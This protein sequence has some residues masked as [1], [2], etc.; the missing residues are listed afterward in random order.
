MTAGESA[1]T[2]SAARSRSWL[3]MGL[4]GAAGVG[5]VF[6]LILFAYELA[7]ARVPQ[8]RAA[9]EHLVRVQTGLDVRF[10]ELGLRWGWY[11]PEAVFR[12]VELDEPGSAQALLRAP[13]L[14]VGFDAWRT[15]RSGHPEAGRIEL[16]APEIDFSGGSGGRR[17]VGV[18]AAVQ[19]AVHG[20]S[21]RSAHGAARGVPHGAAPGADGPSAS[22]D[23]SAL[24]RVAVLQRWRGGRIDIEGG[25]L[26]LP[27]VGGGANLFNSVQIRRASLRRS[28]DEWSVAG[29][30]FLPDRVGR[31]ARITL[32]V[33]G[34]L[35]KPAELS[36]TLR[37]EARRLLFPGC[38]D[39][40]AALPDLARYLPRGGNGDVSVDLNFERGQLVKAHGN[41]RA[42]GVVFDGPAG[43]VAD[44]A[45]GG[46]FAALGFAAGSAVVGGPTA[47]GVARGGSM[48]GG[49]GTGA[50]GGSGGFAAGSAAVGGSGAGTGHA[51]DGVARVGPHGGGA[52]GSVGSGGFAPGSSAAGGP[53]TGGGHA[54][55]GVARVGSIGGGGV[56]AGGGPMLGGLAASGDGL[57]VPRANLLV[58]D[59]FRGDWQVTRLGSGWRVRVD[60]L[61]LVRG[62][63]LGSLTLD[64]SDSAVQ[65]A[66]GRWI[67]GTLE[68][69]P[70]ESVLAVARWLAPHF[71][72]AGIQLDGTARTVAFD[73]ASGRQEGQRLQTSARLDDVALVPRSKDFTLSGLGVRVSGTESQL[74]IDVQSRIARLELGQSQ[75]QPLADVHVS[76][77]LHVSSGRDGW[78]IATDEFLLEHQRASL[79]LS[80]SLQDDPI[81]PRIAATGKLIGA[82]IPLVMRLVGENTAQAFGAAASRLTAGRIEN[83]DFALHGP[84][85]KLPFDA[86]GDGFTGSLTLRN[87]V[88]SGGDLWPDADEIAAH[89]EWRGA[90]IQATIEAGHAGPFQLAAA[91]AQ[92][93]ADGGSATRLTGHV[94]GRLED[95]I[96]WVHDHPGL[97]EYVPDMRYVDASGD[98]SFDFN[99]SVPASLAADVHEP[100]VLARVS[101][102]IDGATVQAISGLPALEGVTGSFV[103][104]AGHLKRS[105]LT[106]SWLGGPVT[107]RVGERREKG[108]PV[109]A[110]QA[111]GTLT[112]QRLATLANAT[113]TVEGSTDWTGELAYLQADNAQAPRWRMRADSNLLGV[114]SSLPEPFAKRSAAVVPVHLEVT[115]AS[116][117]AVLRASLGDRVRSLFAL[118][119]RPDVGWA[120]DRGA[121]R[122]GAGAPVLPSEPVVLVRGRVSELDLPAYAVAWTRLRRDSLPTIRAQMVADEMLVGGRRYNDVSLQ[123]ERTGA[124]TDLLI[125]SA[126]V[127]GMARWPT[128]P[129]LERGEGNTDA[130]QP[131]EL[132][133]TRLD[134]P[135]GTLPSEGIGLLAVLAPAA[136]LSVDEL[137]WKGRSLGRLTASVSTE[138]KLVVMDD[139][140]LVNGTHDGHGALRCQMALPACRLSF[141]MDSSDAAATLVDFGFRPD[142]AASAA[143]LKG[144]VEWR[145]TADASWLASLRGTLSMRLAD[146][147][148]HAARRGTGTDADDS[149]RGVRLGAGSDAEDSRYGTQRGVGIDAGAGDSNADEGSRG[150]VSR[151]DGNARGSSRGDSS[152]DDGRRGSVSRSD[153][154][155]RGSNRGDSDA[156]DGSGG[157]AS[158]GDSSARGSNGD[159]YGGSRNAGDRGPFGLL[160]VPALVSGLDVPG[161]AA[162]SLTKE[163]R[164]LHFARLEA[165]FELHD[166]QATTSNLHFDGDAEI[167]MRGRVGMV[168]RDYD[169][170]VWVLRGEERLPA[171][172]RRFGATPR[173]AAAWLSLRDL[174]V[175][176]GEQDRSQA[177]LRLQGSWD[178]P[179]VVTAN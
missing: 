92:W 6:V 155:A 25:T 41:V 141:T 150:Y 58:L 113:G 161:A 11:G 101:T 118:R 119:R 171:A 138:D 142:V 175:G 72:L 121:V 12:Q 74:T 87:A 135:D 54:A 21:Q 20:A 75:Q 73:W 50:S 91:K 31:S 28:D 158:R 154:N 95:A 144:D 2:K 97:Q 68:Q 89:V 35:G 139:L 103:F 126:A 45:V 111:Q 178:D 13:E 153:G 148:L 37:V 133:L 5:V 124:G 164:E 120:V 160:A 172:V 22:T 83:A 115:G 114:V 109:L 159:S 152:A 108:Q 56:G 100:Q 165:D 36:G 167:L 79:S 4:L 149:P 46:G 122:F 39:F 168:S 3:R 96:A 32:T 157:Y 110:I 127:A 78:Q 57:G 170:Q 146:G 8:H 16:I 117:S 61:D 65:A 140:R 60:S 19:G 105:T 38:R 82:D 102:F 88:L 70:L 98:A 29:L 55:G 9:L 81:E 169:Q 177:V 151:G 128:P 33:T 17:T 44:G 62:E 134:V 64:T 84:I 63:P 23:S 107:L 43:V 145:P 132:H 51:A 18:A 10:N 71:D 52:G 162:A 131:A 30:V 7:R 173:V 47:G 59:R 143:S 24:G 147:S 90:R 53:S 125:D 116:D 176:G 137:N 106:G 104:D 166:G 48:A 15:I 129:G 77:M 163:Q 86:G 27:Q 174:F 69:A 80:G 40:L 156:D 14:V 42:G 76:S 85:S 112:A 67:R 99:V 136:S 93:G 49:L 130:V 66:P 34:D 1:P 94:N 123:A 26:R 179:M